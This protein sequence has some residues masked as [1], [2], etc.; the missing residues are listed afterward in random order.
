[1]AR[2]TAMLWS[3]WQL[4]QRFL[5]QNLLQTSLICLGIAIGTAVVVFITSIISGLQANVI[6][7]TLGTQAH[8]RLEAAQER[9]LLS[10]QVQTQDILL[11]T[12]RAQR[13]RSIANWQ[14]WLEHLDKL[15]ELTAV[16]PSISGPATAER[17]MTRKSIALM[18]IDLNR[19]LQVIDLPAYLK[20]GRLKLGEGDVLIGQQLAQN[21]GLR[22]GD[23]FRL[24]AAQHATTVRVVGIFQ[25][26][27]RDLDA[28]YVYTDLKQS[29]ALLDMPGAVT[30]IDLRINNIFQAESIA[31]QLELRTALKAESWMKNNSQMLNALKS[32]SMATQVIRLFIAISV[33]FGIAS[34]LA[35][36]VTQ[37]T[38]EIGILRAMGGTRRLILTVF[39]MQ[40]GALALLG[41]MLGCLIGSVLV[42]AFNYFAASL[43]TAE[44]SIT[45][46]AYTLLLS[47]IS[48][49]L[50]AAWPAR[51]AALLQPARAIHNV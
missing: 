29:Q 5:R 31:Q 15:P 48:G 41:A 43:F 27:V 7:R 47:V 35:V 12:P 25:I 20:Q 11:H 13:L 37:R 6:D 36:S 34:V 3:A 33:I 38:R 32:Q 19:Y 44:V 8:L 21:L 22:I 40:G 39:L 17:A 51:R 50:A 46:I 23:K 18:G 1:M 26:G 45:L 14:L 28:R 4:A 24:E 49:I 30:G 9:N 10:A 42:H 2:L 16:S